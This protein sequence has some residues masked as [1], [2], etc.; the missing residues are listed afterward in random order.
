MKRKMFLCTFALTVLLLSGC[1]RNDTPG[2]ETPSASNSGMHTTASPEAGQGTVNP[3][4]NSTAT[5][6]SQPGTAQDNTGQ[7]NT[8]Q[9]NAAQNNAAQNGTTHNGGEEGPM[10]SEEDAKQIALSHA[11][12]TSDQVTFI[13]SGLDRDN[14]RLNYDVEFY[15]NEPKEYDYEIDPYTGEVLDVDYDAEYYTQTSTVHDGEGITA[16]DAKKIALD[17]VSGAAASDIREFKSDYDNGRLQYEGKI[18]HEQKE[19]EFEIDGYTGKILE[20]DVEAIYGGV[21]E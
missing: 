1:T 14:G 17:K 21:S 11:G 6:Q 5:G 8:S 16:D 9:N 4:D 13:K 15:T 18:Y 7:N 19:Y 2:T 10:I 20:W 3:S 12:I